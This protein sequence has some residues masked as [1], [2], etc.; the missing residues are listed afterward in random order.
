M[1]FRDLKVEKRSFDIKVKVK[2]LFSWYNMQGDNNP[3]SKNFKGTAT[4]PASQ[5]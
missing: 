1:Y 4:A 2:A 3:K 5:S